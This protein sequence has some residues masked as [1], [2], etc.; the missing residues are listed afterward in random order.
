MGIEK[1]Q[2]PRDLSEK[3]KALAVAIVMLAAGKA[4]RMGKDGGFKLL[5]EFDGLPL[6]RRSAMTALKSEAAS[7]AVVTGHRSK[8]IEDALSGLPL[9]LV[10]NFGYASG[11]A[12]SLIAGFSDQAVREAD[13]VLVMLAD[14]PGVSTA[15]LNALIAAFREADGGSIVRATWHGKP[16]NPAILPRTLHDAVMRLAGDVGARRIIETSGLPVV[17]VDIGE[18]AH[19]DVDT[20][21]AVIFAGGIL[22][23]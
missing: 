23:G 18:A 8:D 15:D 10:M 3:Q 11:M 21:E 4:S 6:V 13:G 5:A 16:G 2:P 9:S 17:D 1:R 7:V 12:S 19:F 20:P 14:M 22:K